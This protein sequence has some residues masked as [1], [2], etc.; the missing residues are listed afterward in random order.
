MPPLEDSLEPGEGTHKNTSTS[1]V[2]VASALHKILHE[3]A[4]PVSDQCS[5]SCLPTR[6]GGSHPSSD[7]YGSHQSMLGCLEIE[8]THQRVC[9]KRD[10]ADGPGVATIGT[11]GFWR[12]MVVCGSTQN[13]TRQCEHPSIDYG[14]D[15]TGPPMLHRK[16]PREASRSRGGSMWCKISRSLANTLETKASL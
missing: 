4:T 11:Q 9:C 3:D 5:T 8:N 10:S 16:W 7:Y 15:G 14:N 13:Q 6:V 1:C 2:H 12:N